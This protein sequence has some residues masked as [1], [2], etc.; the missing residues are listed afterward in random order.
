MVDY[1]FYTQD[2]LGEDIP[3]AAWPRFEKR[4]ADLLAR[5]K[6]T[7]PVTARP[8]IENAE[9]CA[10]CA[11]ADAMYEFAQEDEGRGLAKVT[12]GSVSE[13]YVAP[14][15]LCATTLSLREAHYRREA[16]YYIQIGRWTADA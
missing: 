8:G 6:A 7:F 5:W 11:V 1:A 3:E 12:V 14:A 4:A 15:A 2:F 13:S 10:V 9:L 16:G